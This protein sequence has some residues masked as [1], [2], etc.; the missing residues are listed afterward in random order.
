MIFNPSFE[1]ALS[2]IL[3]YDKILFFFNKSFNASH[4]LKPMRFL[5]NLSWFA[6]VIDDKVMWFSKVLNSF[7]APSN[8]M[9][10]LPR[11]KC[12]KE[13]FYL[14]PLSKATNPALPKLFLPKSKWLK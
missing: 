3:I 1:I 10:L 12:I 13:Q 6:S 11:S 8:V 14:M 5:C 2:E 9:S 4:A 7:A